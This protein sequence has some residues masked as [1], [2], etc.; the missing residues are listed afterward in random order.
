[1][2][3]IVSQVRDIYFNCE[4][5]K[6]YLCSNCRRSISHVIEQASHKI[7]TLTLLIDM[8]RSVPMLT[9]WLT[10]MRRSYVDC[11]STRMPL[12]K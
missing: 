5:C 2:S 7:E 4:D 10:Q 6:T 3:S 1:M 9:D 8:F 12:H 11:T